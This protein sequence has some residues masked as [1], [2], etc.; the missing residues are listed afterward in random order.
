MLANIDGTILLCFFIAMLL[1]GV[2]TGVIILTKLKYTIVSFSCVVIAIISWL[3]NFGLLRFMMTIL[4]LPI[5]HTIV[6]MIIN[7]F[8]SSY[9]RKSG[10]LKKLVILTHITY[11]LS[12]LLFPDMLDMGSE[13]MFFGLIDN[14]I[15]TVRCF[16]LAIYSFI[17][18]IIF[19]ILQIIGI[20][21][22]K[23]KTI[24]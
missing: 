8:S 7:H 14:N 24:Q 18:N 17:A 21:Y 12:Y 3:L 23:R 2:S 6:Y 22:V 4:A 10:L 9:I 19:L 20:V 16:D 11:L 13:C 1:I 15:I 5:I